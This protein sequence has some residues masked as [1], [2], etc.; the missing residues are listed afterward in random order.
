MKCDITLRCCCAEMERQESRCCLVQTLASCVGL[1]VH[2]STRLF[3][4]PGFRADH[5]APS[6]RLTT[7]CCC[8]ADVQG[9]GEP[10]VADGP[11]RAAASGDGRGGPPEAE[12]AAAGRWGASVPSSARVTATAAAGG[13]V[14]S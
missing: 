12:P 11:A 3:A 8:H 13:G 6:A 10:L 4:A 5:R 14:G 1:L 2:K 7:V 9:A